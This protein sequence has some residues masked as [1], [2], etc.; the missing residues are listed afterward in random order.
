[1]GRAA[2]QQQQQQKQDQHHDSKQAGA[3]Q[4]DADGPTVDNWSE[5]DQRI[6]V[7]TPSDGYLFDLQ[8]HAKVGR[9]SRPLLPNHQ[10]NSEAGTRTAHGHVAVDNVHVLTWGTPL[11]LQ[12]DGSPRQ[13][14]NI[15][16]DPGESSPTPAPQLQKVLH[17]CCV[18]TYLQP[19]M[20]P[21]AMRTS[22]DALQAVQGTALCL[23]AQQ[24]MAGSAVHTQV[25]T[26]PWST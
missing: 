23:A 24:R 1:M 4:D 11:L 5:K 21:A 2:A 15:L 22:A 9:S 6:I 14:Y 26:L 7:A 8:L 13:V 19:W 17:P 3:A 12:L 10:R 20:V 25:S 16:T 18:E